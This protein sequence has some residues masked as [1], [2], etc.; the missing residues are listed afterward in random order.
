MMPPTAH[1]DARSVALRDGRRR[2]VEPSPWGPHEWL[3]RAGVTAAQQL[4]LVRVTMPAGKGH[5]FHRHPA[6]EEIIYVVVGPRRAMGRPR[7]AAARP[8]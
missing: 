2:V 8:G 5:A 4:M 6:M 3:S 7:L 1:V